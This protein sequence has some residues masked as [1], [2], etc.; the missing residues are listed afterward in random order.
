MK[1]IGIVSSPRKGG[2]SQSLVEHILSGAQDAG[3]TIEL[4]RLCD[5]D[6]KPCTGCDV[7][8]MDG[9]CVMQD[10][11][12]EIYGKV[13][14]SDVVV[15]GSPIYWFRLCA[16]AYPFIDRIY[17]HFTLD[18]TCDMPKGKKIVEI[19]TFTG[20]ILREPMDDGVE[21]L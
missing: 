1:I 14:K 11:M 4:I 9:E 12:E 5:Y 10:D 17:G 19:E 21:L 6:I 16:Q 18:F 8:K 20:E 15:F 2:N 13:I 7:C 3:A